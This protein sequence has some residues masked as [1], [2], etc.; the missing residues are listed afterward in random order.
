MT[1]IVSQPIRV[2]TGPRG[3]F[4][5]PFEIIDAYDDF[6]ASEQEDRGRDRTPKRTALSLP[7]SPGVEGFRRQSINATHHHLPPVGSSIPST[8][9][10]YLPPLLS[11]LPHEHKDHSHTGPTEEE[12]SNFNTRLPDID[13]ASLVLHQALHRFSPIDDQYAKRRYSTAFNWDQLVSLS[14]MPIA[15]Y[16]DD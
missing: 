12:L 3:S 13:P 9:I 7:S 2:P 6:P 1:A 5:N 16:A 14:A 10:L 4:I 11:P 8:P 15:H